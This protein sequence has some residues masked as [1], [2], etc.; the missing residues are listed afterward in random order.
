MQQC[1][2]QGKQKEMGN[3][4]T[5]R[6]LGHFFCSYSAWDAQW[7]RVM[8]HCLKININ[9]QR[10]L[11]F[12]G[13]FLALQLLCVGYS[14]SLGPALCEFVFCSPEKWVHVGEVSLNRCR[15]SSQH[16]NALQMSKQQKQELANWWYTYFFSQLLLQINCLVQVL[17]TGC[18]RA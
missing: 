11:Q 13:S 10:F 1:R 7:H 9:F 3:H 2:R 12:Y 18:Y 17:L 6:L 14:A 8:C 4:C 15:S 16:P 5:V